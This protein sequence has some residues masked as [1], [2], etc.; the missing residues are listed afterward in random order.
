MIFATVPEAFD[1]A[2]KFNRT[3]LGCGADWLVGLPEEFLRREVRKMTLAEA[4]RSSNGKFVKGAISKALL[5]KIYSTLE[6]RQ[7]AVKLSPDFV[8]YVAEPVVWTVEYRCFVAEQNIVTISP[9]RRLGEIWEETEQNPSPSLS[10]PEAE[11][12]EAR[13]FANSFLKCPAVKC[14]PAFVLDIGQIENRGWAVLEANECWASGIYDSDP[15]KILSV[16]KQA[17]IPNSPRTHVHENWD[18]AAH[19]RAACPR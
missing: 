15:A 14:P 8:V 12:R 3:L 19:Y 10:A 18:F 1:I 6:L 5:G 7:A 9:Y 16:L 11:L 2:E 17:C 13:D 4:L